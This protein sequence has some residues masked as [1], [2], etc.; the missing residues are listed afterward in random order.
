[1]TA[2]EDASEV[3]TKWEAIKRAEKGRESVF[4]GIDASLPALLHA[5]KVVR[6]AESL[7]LAAELD[8]AGA[9]RR[10]ASRQ[11]TVAA[12]ARAERAAADRCPYR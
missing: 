7:G 11:Q 6:K 8:L 5:Q 12:Q 3:L 9:A 4:D 10:L 1:M 2:V